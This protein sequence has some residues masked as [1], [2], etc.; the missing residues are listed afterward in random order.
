MKRLIIAGLLCACAPLAGAQNEAPA[1]P[2][3]PVPAPDSAPVAEP[4]PAPVA[5]A[6]AAPQ[7]EIIDTKVGKGKEAAP[8]RSVVMHYTGW[9]Y[10]PKAKNKHGK[11]FDSSFDAGRT[12]ID[13]T[14]GAGR[15][16]RGWE[17]GV[18]GMKAGGKRTLIIPPELGYGARGAGAFI[19]P[20]ATLVFDIELLK[21]Q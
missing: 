15:M 21:V 20:N 14:L 7:V 3:V 19:P 18:P 6:P 16:I 5:E 2:L 11:K 1:T 12:P 8:G 10:N 13:F 9:L 4:A 17:Q